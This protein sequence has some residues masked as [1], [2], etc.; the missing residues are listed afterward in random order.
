MEP[1][2]GAEPADSAILVALLDLVSRVV[3]AR[4]TSCLGV[5]ALV[6]GGGERD[7]V[8]RASSSTSMAK[9]SD[10]PLGSVDSGGSAETT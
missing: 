5:D 10:S 9:P 3:T 1:E 2:E 7:S 4:L 8:S 6:V